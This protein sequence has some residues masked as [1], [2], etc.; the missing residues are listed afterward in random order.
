MSDN[1]IIALLDANVLYPAPLRDYL[2]RLAA[3]GLYIPKWSDEIQEEWMFHLLKN[4][5]DLKRINLEKT[6]ELMNLAFPD[7]NVSGYSKLIS[8]LKLPDKND[9]HILATA[10]IS[11]ASFIITFNTKDFPFTVVENYGIKVIE[12]NEFIQ[13]LNNIDTKRVRNAF[14]S[15]LKS[16]KN[17][18]VSKDRLIRILSKNGLRDI[19]KFVNI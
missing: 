17:P 13:L 4:R 8:K 3:E 6:K 14:D 18:P 9:R 5:T 16:L 12:P 2:L 1:N 10:I 7:S 19:E 15:Q 11:S